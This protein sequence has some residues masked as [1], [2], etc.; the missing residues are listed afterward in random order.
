MYSINRYRKL[1]L[2]MLE[3][4]APL[5]AAYIISWFP[6]S[7][8]NRLGVVAIV[9]LHFFAFR[10]SKV[11][12]EIET[13]GYWIEAE[14]TF[15]YSV[16]FALL[17]TFVSFML[18]GDVEISRRG[19][20]Y[21]SIINFILVY[22]V[23]LLIRKYKVYTLFMGGQQKK[24][25]LI[26]T[27]NRYQHMKNLFEADILPIKYLTGVVM[28]DGGNESELPVP[29]VSFDEAV[30]FATHEV[31]DHVFINLP[32][33][34]Y[35]LKSLVYD[36]EVLGIDVSVD[37]NSFDFHTL[38]NKRIQQVGN[39]SIVTFSSNLY[40]SSHV[41][42][43]RLLDIIGAIVGMILFGLASIVLV[44][45]IKRDGGPAIFVQDRVG[46]NGR[47]F[48]FYKFRSMYLDAEERKQDL[49]DQNQMQ[50]GMFKMDND[51]RI[52]P[53]GHFI[54]KTSLDELPQFYNVLRGDMSL[55]GTRPP[56]L[57]EFEKYTPSQKRRLSF[58]PGITGLWQVS[59]RS[60]ITNFDEVVKLDV[61]YID[62]WTIMSDIKILTKTVIS[63]L[64]REGS[65]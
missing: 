51:P 25:L 61:E 40:K 20:L 57:D 22:V 49:L 45:I 26:T 7:Q 36:Y 21:F 59:G 14:R 24:T 29:L 50:G 23:N 52:T 16:I 60:N 64:R 43:K 4:F 2:A 62:N 65:K 18:E 47:V 31:V 6:D 39:H 44:P 35:D 48:K 17:L 5:S 30:E 55:V 9:I 12:A 10:L 15:S 54:R 58:K 1:Q 46:K 28:V 11:H 34:A 27:S 41:I 3:L 33:E 37:I 32:S 56:T 42:L 13:R 19:V 38:Q 8:L 63:V 53:I